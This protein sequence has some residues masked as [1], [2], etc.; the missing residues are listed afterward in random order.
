MAVLHGMDSW[1]PAVTDPS[2]VCSSHCLSSPPLHLPGFWSHLSSQPKL[3]VWGL[4]PPI[5]HPFLSDTS[6]AA[7]ILARHFQVTTD[8]F[9]SSPTSRLVLP[10]PMSP[11]KCFSSGF[12]LFHAHSVRI[13]HSSVIRITHSGICWVRSLPTSSI[14]CSKGLLNLPEILLLYVCF[15]QNQPMTP[16]F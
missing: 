6:I 2:Q 15:V 5:F 12:L 4:L 10:G 11:S 9:L 1:C 14:L 3:C 8:S 16:V 13:V 7:V